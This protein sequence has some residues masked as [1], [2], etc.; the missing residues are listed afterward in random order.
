MKQ[1][2]VVLA[3]LGFGSCFLPIVYIMARLMGE[4]GIAAVQ[5]VADVLTLLLAVPIIKT[6]FRRIDNAEEEYLRE[7]TSAAKQEAL[8]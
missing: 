3:G 5:A 4:N 1:I 2:K 7:Q 6:V 8:A